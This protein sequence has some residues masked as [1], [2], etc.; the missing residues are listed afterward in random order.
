[1]SS[2][3]TDDIALFRGVPI[4]SL[5]IW[6]CF[7]SSLLGG[8]VILL[9]DR[10]IEWSWQSKVISPVSSRDTFT[11]LSF[12]D[13]LNEHGLHLQES[14]VLGLISISFLNC[15]FPLHNGQSI[16]INLL[17]NRCSLVSVIVLGSSSLKTSSS[18]IALLCFLFGGIYIYF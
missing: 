3:L 2:I 11:V 18:G 9:K 4:T 12:F 10:L 13:S 5:I 6:Y 16:I 7:C 1:M 14:P 8:V 15:I 17:V